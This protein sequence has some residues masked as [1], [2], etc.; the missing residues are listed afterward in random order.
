MKLTGKIAL[1]TGAGSGFGRASALLF[2]QDYHV[3]LL[4]G[5][6]PHNLVAIVGAA[7]KVFLTPAVLAMPAPSVQGQTTG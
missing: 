7:V 1:I 5:D 2:A 4:R 3:A 6:L